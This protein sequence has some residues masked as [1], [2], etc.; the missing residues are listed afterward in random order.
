MALDPK[1]IKQLR[2]DVEEINRI[3]QKIGEQPLKVDFDTAGKDDIKLIRDYLSEARTFVTDIDEGFG[4][5][6]RSI[7]NIVS[8]WKKGFATP[9]SEA[10]KSFTKLKGIAEKLSDDFKGVAEL[11]GNEVKSLKDQAKFEVERL[12]VL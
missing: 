11:R 9:T 10:T 5:M 8:E 4:G 1:I 6:T 7:K 3:Y 12:I 2:K